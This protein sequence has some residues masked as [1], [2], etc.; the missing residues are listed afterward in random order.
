MLEAS[1]YLEIVRKRAVKNQGLERVHR[2][3][4]KES[5]LL[6]AYINLYPNKGANTPGIDSDDVIDGMSLEKIKT[7][8][9]K[10]KTGVFKWKPVKRIYI[11]KKSGGNKRP[12]GIP[13][14]SEKLVQE[15]MRI[16]LEEYYEPKFSNNSHGFR[17]NRGCH[18]ALKQ[19]A[20]KKWTGAK[21][22]IEGDVKGCFD[23][24]NHKK[25]L[26][27]LSRDIK[28]SKFLKLVK[29]ML[30]SGYMEN[31]K[32]KLNYS[33]TQQGG[34]ISPLLSN[35]YLN[36]LDKF[37][38]EILMPKYSRG[39]RKRSNVE[40]QKLARQRYTAK[41]AGNK[42]EAK[43]ILKS[44]RK[45]PISDTHDPN[46]RRL[47]YI[48]YADDFVLGFIGPKEEAKKIKE[49]IAEFLMNKLKLELSM[50]KTLITSAS[51]EIARFLNYEVNAGVINHKQTKG[52]N[53]V[54][55]RSINGCI[56]LRMPKDVLRNWI[57]KF[58]KKGKPVH[59][60]ELVN[61]SDYDI[62][63]KY[64]SELQGLYNYYIL[65]V[66]V[67]K[68]NELNY[69]MT[70]SLAKTLACKH[71]SYIDFRRVLDRIIFKITNSLIATFGNM[72][73][74]R[75]KNNFSSK[76]QEDEFMTVYNRRSELLK[77]MLADK[78]ELCG[79][80]G[81]IEIHHIRKMSDLK[82]KYNIKKGIPEWKERMISINRKTLIVC[83][84]C[85]NLI[86][87]GKYDGKKLTKV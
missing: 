16:I 36:E 82:R 4:R 12:L 67:S 76:Y 13:G 65:A 80:E 73:L 3:I 2:L 72:K 64:D 20:Y 61:L 81:H 46:F 45:I 87:S 40:Y 58:S 39:K 5:I 70:Y 66:N 26:E 10:L 83:K 53:G 30:K 44:M 7:L 38:E 25:L 33:G 50:E 77:R 8:S 37:I 49:E 60:S 24:I 68:M 54:K 59:R 6:Q 32:F 74:K 69:Y 27:I 56:Q 15:A 19:I 79:K 28:D 48:R 86:H 84:N 21:W 41:K 85:H 14:W 42:E 63:R 71:N 9:K 55:Q 11:P 62:I 35:I 75:R 34:V 51:Q 47:K 31:W 43:A 29:D 57:R 52:I 78:C 1:K 23:N 17:R 18:T 22:F